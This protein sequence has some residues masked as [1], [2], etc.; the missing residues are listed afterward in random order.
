[1][2]AVPRMD[3]KL[4]FRLAELVVDVND[5]TV[6]FAKSR[7]AIARTLNKLQ[8][9][10]TFKRQAELVGSSKPLG[11]ESFSLGRPHKL[12]VIELNEEEEEEDSLREHSGST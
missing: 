4:A 11:S 5:S 3:L 2:C 7:E 12:G 8:L 1:M 10:A 6:S 9:P